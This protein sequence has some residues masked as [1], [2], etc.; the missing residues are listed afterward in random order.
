MSSK[1]NLAAGVA[2]LGAAFGF[3]DAVQ[4]QQR[5]EEPTTQEVLAPS[6]TCQ[7]QWDTDGD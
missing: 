6:G 2:A 1:R 5:S 4:G 3:T 7:R